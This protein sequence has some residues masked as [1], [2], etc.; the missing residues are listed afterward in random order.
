VTEKISWLFIVKEG[1]ERH[2]HA[3][4]DIDTHEVESGGMCNEVVPAGGV[5]ACISRMM[6]ASVNQ[7]LGTE[8]R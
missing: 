8:R 1:R 2:A 4:T 7:Y 3:D 5:C 6:T